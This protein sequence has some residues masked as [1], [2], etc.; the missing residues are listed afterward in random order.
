M[1]KRQLSSVLDL[2]CGVGM[3]AR[4]IRKVL[5]PEVT[6]YGVD[7]YW[8]YLNSELAPL[9]DVRI[10]ASIFDFVDGR[11]TIPVDCVICMDVI[12]HCDRA[13][14]L[15]LSDWLLKQPMAYLSTPLFDFQQGA[16]GGNS[17]E[18]HRTWFSMEELQEMGWLPI[19]KIEWDKRGWIGAF[20]SHE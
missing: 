11:I 12:E 13:Q 10:N 16:V 1:Y 6:L 18:C 2:G 20:K 8:P 19:V 5:P 14:A 3:Y 4:D 15:R 7:G 17:L 9:Y